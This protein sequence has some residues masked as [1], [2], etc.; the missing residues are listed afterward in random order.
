[1]KKEKEKGAGEK[2]VSALIVSG[3]TRKTAAVEQGTL[4]C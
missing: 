1:M 3:T 2:I 4:V